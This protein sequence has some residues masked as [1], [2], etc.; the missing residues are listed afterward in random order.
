MVSS[1]IQGLSKRPP[2]EFCNFLGSDKT[3]VFL[4]WVDRDPTERYLLILK[5]PIVYDII[6][7][8]FETVHTPN[9]VGY[10][11]VTGT[12][13]TA[14]RTVTVAD[15][16]FI[17][18]TE[19]VVRRIDTCNQP[20]AAFLQFV[21][22]GN[23]SDGGSVRIPDGFQ[24]ILF[25]FDNNGASTPGRT[26]VPIAA[27]SM[28]TMTNL[29]AAIEARGLFIKITRTEDRIDMVNDQMGSFVNAGWEGNLISRSR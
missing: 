17:V 27:N 10:L 5:A 23:P 2:L 13:Q 20:A 3:N 21:G 8:N 7:R 18:N 12:A 4:H 29:K 6:N 26:R 25:E 28:L 19:M 16:T 9:G 11:K 24:A 15:F 1:L 14:F 22:G